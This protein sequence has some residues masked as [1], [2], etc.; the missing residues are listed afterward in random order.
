MGERTATHSE[1]SVSSEDFFEP[2]MGDLDDE[3]LD[4]M[5]DSS[6]DICSPSLAEKRRRAEQRLETLRLR[7]ELGDFDFELY[8]D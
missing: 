5:D 2:L 1:D 6:I 3:M 7:E 8:D 4:A